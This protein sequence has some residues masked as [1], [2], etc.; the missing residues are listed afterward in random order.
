MSWDIRRG[1]PFPD[2]TIDAC[3]ASH[4]VEHLRPIEAHNLLGHMHR[5]LR[6]GGTVR[7]VVPDLEGIARAYLDA[8][9][10]VIAGEPGALSDHAWMVLELYDQMVRESGGGE[11]ARF[12]KQP[13]LENRDFIA[14]RIGSEARAN[15]TPV[16][17]SRTGI[18]SRL[19]ALRARVAIDR[20]R[21]L[22]SAWVLRLV[23]GSSAAGAFAQGLARRSGEIH[24]AMYD[25]V[26]L[27]R[28]LE[29]HGFREIKRCA[30]TESRI[31][32]FAKYGLDSADGEVLKPDSLYMEGVRP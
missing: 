24:L 26:S 32:D 28:L 16:A 3:Y 25:R 15:W 21:T 1:L 19:R 8:L 17:V 18:L 9:G 14:S 31:P 10:R 23:G 29:G 30:A 27:K 13:D 6:P 2:A 12:L 20:A 5:V 22:V 11:M 7:L 4:V